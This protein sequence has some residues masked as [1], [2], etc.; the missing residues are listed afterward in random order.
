METATCPWCNAPRVAEANCPRCG[1]NYAKAAL[2]KTQGRAVA[3]A[4]SIVAPAPIV[5]IEERAVQ[6]P[7][8]EL[9]L[10]VAAIPAALALG[11][12]F[13]L[14]M[15]GVQRIFLGVPVH[16]LGHAVSAWFCGFWAIPTLWKTIIPDERGLI[17]PILLAGALGTMMFRAYQAEKFHLIVIGG[18]LL[19]LQGIGTFVIREST[20]QMV[21][22][23]GGDGVGMVL[24]TALMAT[25]FFG[26]RSQ[27]YKGSLRWGFLMIGAAAFVDMFATWW[28]ARSDIGAIPYGEIE[29]VGLSDSA[30]L[31]EEYGWSV[32]ALVQRYVLVGVLCLLALALVYAWGVW[33]AWRKAARSS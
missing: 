6:D 25:F 24:A 2:I 27:L 13:H 19:V 8:L 17:A 15:P 11:L 7:A 21:F 1:A 31:V 9:K 26:K 29:G 18:V 28:A 23:F 10:C 12:V 30:R 33:H 32:T 3:A 16:E 14:V 22:S 4:A 5:G 20:A